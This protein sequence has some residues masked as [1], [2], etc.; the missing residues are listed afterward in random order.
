MRFATSFRAGFLS[1]WGGARVR[2]IVAT[3]VGALAFAVLIALLERGGGRAGAADRALA[4][5]F[6]LLVPLSV[7][8]LTTLALGPRNLRDATWPVARFGH[9]KSAVALGQLGLATALGAVTTLA[10]VLIAVLVTHAT[11]G[12]SASSLSLGHDLFTS[13]WIAVLV[14][15]SYAAWLTA[16]A[17]F[18]KRGGGRGVVLI[19]DFVV[20]DAG[21]FGGIMPRGVAYNL[22]GHDAAMDLGQ[23]AASA[24]GL[25]AV[26]LLWAL[27]ALRCRD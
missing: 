21:S 18:G 16:G 11:A 23:R 22:I 27:V 4:T 24:I 25:A 5:C 20:G 13:G 17:T 7:A 8:A 14:G 19:L 10:V 6:R 3:M 2:A 26:V 9:S 12:A 15:A 1:A